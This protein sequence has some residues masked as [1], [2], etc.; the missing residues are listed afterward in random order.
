VIR[1]ITDDTFILRKRKK[2]IP[3]GGYFYDHSHKPNR[4][5]YV[6]GQNFIVMVALVDIAG[7]TAALPVLADLLESEGLLFWPHCSLPEDD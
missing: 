2:K 1:L 4:P 6:F 5:D 3:C 7:T